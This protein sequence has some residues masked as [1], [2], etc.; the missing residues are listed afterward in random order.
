[1]NLTL[2][3]KQILLS[4]AKSHHKTG[5]LLSMTVTC[6]TQPWRLSRVQPA[7][8]PGRSRFHWFSKDKCTSTDEPCLRRPRSKSK[9]R[10]HAR[11]LTRRPKAGGLLRS[12]DSGSVLLGK[13]HRCH[14]P[15]TGRSLYSHRSGKASFEGGGDTTQRYVETPGFI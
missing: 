9:H 10:R 2:K 4:I 13:H 7:A 12:G 3:R 14:K 6:S 11:A 15:C 5:L 1:M 8:A